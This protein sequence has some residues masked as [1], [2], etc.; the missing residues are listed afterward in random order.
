MLAGMVRLGI[1]STEHS[2]F[3]IEDGKTLYEGIVVEASPNTKIINLSKPNN[4]KGIKV[5]F[6][7]SD[8][9]NINDRTFYMRIDYSYY[10]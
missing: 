8:N 9:L 1:V 10:R 3:T 5:V 2:P 7:I 6:R 4:V